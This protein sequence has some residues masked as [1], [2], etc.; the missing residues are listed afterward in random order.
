MNTTRALPVVI[1]LAAAWSLSDP[2]SAQSARVRGADASFTEDFERYS[3]PGGAAPL[4]PQSG[5]TSEND[6]AMLV[7]SMSAIE[8]LSGRHVADSTGVAEIA[9]QSPRF[10]ASTGTLAADIRIDDNG[11]HP[12]YD[13]ALYDTA[14]FY[15][16]ARVLFDDDGFIKVGQAQSTRADYVYTNTF[17]DW[18]NE[19]FRLAVEVTPGGGLIV[20]K[21]GEVIF[22][23]VETVRALFGHTGRPDQ[24]IISTRN[25]L[26]FGQP[27]GSGLTID[28]IAFQPTP[29]PMDVNGDGTVDGDDI[30]ALTQSWRS[31]DPR[32]ACAADVNGDGRTDSKDL[33]LILGSWGACP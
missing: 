32:T 13:L 15:F 26:F 27:D 2:G 30:Q 31:C 17:V 10:P 11:A 1:A 4:A 9:M 29:C 8:G 7:V 28:N 21:N 3:A 5:W 23:G 33:A 25:A 22:T 20:R 24:L 16:C 12:R 6:A 14:E 19:T 18:R